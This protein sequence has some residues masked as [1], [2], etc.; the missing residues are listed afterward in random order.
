VLAHVGTIKAVFGVAIV[1]LGVAILL[2]YDKHLEAFLVN[3]MPDAW[4]DL[5]TKF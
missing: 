4:I 5:T 2:G 1:L 3:L